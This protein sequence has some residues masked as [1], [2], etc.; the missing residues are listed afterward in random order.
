[1]TKEEFIKYLNDLNIKIT[2]KQ[3]NQLEKYYEILVEKNK[4]MNLT[5]ITEKNQ[6]YLKH[7]YDSLT[8]QKIIN[9]N[10]VDT[11]CDLGTGAGFPGMVIKILFPHI[12]VTLV[13]SLNKRVN[14]LK[15][16][17]EE[18]GLEKI[19]ILHERF[20]DYA[21]CNEE[22]FDIVT[23]RAV[24]HLSNILEYSVRTIK[25]NGYFIAMKSSLNEELEE[26][27]EAIKKLDMKLEKIEE[28]EL[29]F[30][31]SK[32]TLVKLKKINKTNKKYPRKTSEIKK[33]RL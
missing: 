30:E 3:L 23:A 7:F 33:K 20:E 12:K 25:I 16:V 19:E 18:L 26:S 9:L 21:R 11:F 28:F 6:V 2:D 29:P 4:V 1:M 15:E 27:K 32:R 5:G 14:F 31:E 17:K 10:E 13:D 8:L 24:S 22:K